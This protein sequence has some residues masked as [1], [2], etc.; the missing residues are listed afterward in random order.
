MKLTTMTSKLINYLVISAIW[1]FGIMSSPLWSAEFSDLDIGEA[2]KGSLSHNQPERGFKVVCN[3]GDYLTGYLDSP[4]YPLTLDVIN[5]DGKIIRRLVHNQSGKN[6]FYLVAENCSNTWRVSGLGR[7]NL[8]LE[9]QVSIEDQAPPQTES[10]LS[11]RVK[12]L[13]NALKVGSTTD[14]FWADVE[15]SGTPL[16]EKTPAG[17]LM[18]FLARGDYSNVKLLGAPSNDHESLKR[19]GQSDTWYK[20]F[21]VP[22]DTHLSYQIAPNVPYPPFSGFARRVAIK[23]VAQQDPYNHFPWP[24]SSIDKY[25]GY[26]TISLS[27]KTKEPKNQITEVAKKGTLSSFSFT[28]PTLKNTRNI[29]IYTPALKN[30][31]P[32]LLYIFDAQKYLEL[33]ELPKMLDELIANKNIPPVITVFI[34]NPDAASR[35]NEL[36]A[37][38][39]FADALANELV[40]QV[41][42]RLNIPIPSTRVIVAGSSYGGLAATNAALRHPKVFGNVLSM[43][44]SFWWAPKENQINSQHYMAKQFITMSQKP[45]RLFLSAGL[46]ET[47]RGVGDGILETNRH[48]RDVLLAKGYTT[49]YKEYSAGHDYFSWRDIIADGLMTLFPQM[50]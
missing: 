39:L 11:P 14:S 36:P 18:T 19:L 15:E 13:E 48:L 4:K 45:I 3:K 23:A 43:S 28:S 25:S 24:A 46:F 33:V 12:T 22:Q 26:S 21:H 30:Q 27:T 38:N 44:G 16:I 9:A 41:N 32:L 49:Y 42:Q 34:S 29:T 10:P 8:K 7:Y 47:S 17:I 35:A 1:I 31:A 6:Y 20:S 2:F 50:E 40:P 37:N 5:S